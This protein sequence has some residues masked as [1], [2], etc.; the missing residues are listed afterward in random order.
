MLAKNFNL[1]FYPKKGKIFL[2]SEPT[3]LYA[4]NL[5]RYTQVNFSWDKVAF[6]SLE[7]QR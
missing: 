6:G 1:L 7:F 4:H 2:P 3:H 5:E